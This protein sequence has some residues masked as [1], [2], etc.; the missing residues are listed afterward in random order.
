M[1]KIESD[2]AKKLKEQR[3]E[4]LLMFTAGEEER[5]R[6]ERMKVERAESDS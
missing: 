4:Q 5:A 3:D 2:V 6:I 1:L